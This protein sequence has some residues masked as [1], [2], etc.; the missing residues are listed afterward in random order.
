VAIEATSGRIQGILEEVPR[1]AE[2]MNGRLLSVCVLPDDAPSDGAPVQFSPTGRYATRVRKT[3]RQQAG[4]PD[5]GET[6][7]AER[8]LQDLMDSLNENRRRAG[9]EPIF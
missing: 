1:Y 9:A 6:T 3:L 8:D 5:A 7:G 4:V 2:T